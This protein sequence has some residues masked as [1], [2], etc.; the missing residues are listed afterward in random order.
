[1]C[2]QL[3]SRIGG[4]TYEGVFPGDTVYTGSHKTTH[5]ESH[6]I[7]TSNIAQLQKIAYTQFI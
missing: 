4:V 2:L 1:M 7:I 3:A 5:L 6:V